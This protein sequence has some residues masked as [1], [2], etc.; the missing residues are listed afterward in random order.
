MSTTTYYAQE[1][2]SYCE[3]IFIELI[4]YCSGAVGISL[5]LAIDNVVWRVTEEDTYRR[6]TTQL[7]GMVG[8]TGK[9]FACIS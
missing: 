5:A 3:L 7:F 4:H 1:K 9:H 2:L 6:Y 8:G